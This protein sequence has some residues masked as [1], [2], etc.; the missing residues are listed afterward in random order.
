VP[1]PPDNKLPENS[2]RNLDEKLDQAIEE[3]FPTSDPVSVTITKGGAID[4]DDNGQITSDVAPSAEA[5]PIM[6]RAMTVI[7][8]YEPLRHGRRCGGRFDGFLAPV[9]LAGKSETLCFPR[10]PETTPKRAPYAVAAGF[11]AT[12]RAPFTRMLSAA[13]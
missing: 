3:T 1:Q 13:F 7:E 12:A 11:R 9:L 5:E 8:S 2:K 6:G 4:Y 10:R